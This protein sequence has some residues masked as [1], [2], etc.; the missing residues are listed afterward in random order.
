[1]EQIT[2]GGDNGLP[3]WSPDGKRLAYTNFQ[4]DPGTG[5]PIFRIFVLNIDDLSTNFVSPGVAPAWSPDG[6]AIAFTKPSVASPDTA[7][8]WVMQPDGSGQQQVTNDPGR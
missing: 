5:M 4:M 8:I 7:E 6:S 2:S 1:M 3:S